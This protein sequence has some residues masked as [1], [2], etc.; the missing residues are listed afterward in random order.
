MIEFLS[1]DD[2]LVPGDV[3]G[4]GTVGGGCGLELDRWVQPGDVMELT[5]DKIG[6][7]RNRVIRHGAGV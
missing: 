6:T 5:V 7:L 3:I 4:S 1:R 2:T